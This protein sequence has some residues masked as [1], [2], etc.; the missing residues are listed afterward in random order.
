MSTRTTTTSIRIP[1][2]LLDRFDRLAKAT[3]RTRS[4]HVI[5]ALEAYIAEQDYLV[6]LFAEATAEADADPTAVTNADAA[7]TAIAAG[8]LRPEDLEGP[9][10]VSDEEYEAAQQLSVRWR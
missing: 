2:D 4:Y 3:D 5:K 8:L 1:G 9:D 10:P 7:A 6:N